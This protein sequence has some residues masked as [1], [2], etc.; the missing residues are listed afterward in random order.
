LSSGWLVAAGPFRIA[1]EKTQTERGTLR[2]TY[3]VNAGYQVEDGKTVLIIDPYISQFRPG[4][5]GPTDVNDKSDPILAPDTD[6]IDKHISR[7]DYILITHSH[8]DHLLDA[9]YIASK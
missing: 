1:A 4:G 9:P 8:S 6:G 2:L 7:A 5:M 3:L